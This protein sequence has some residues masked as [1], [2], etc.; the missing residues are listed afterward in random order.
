MNVND[1]FF[2]T[3]KALKRNPI[4]DLSSS[5]RSKILNE[6]IKGEIKEKKNFFFTSE[7]LLKGEFGDLET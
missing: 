1:P 6:E 4:E 2:E 5:W 7:N 3:S